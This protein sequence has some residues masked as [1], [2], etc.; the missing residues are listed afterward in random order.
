MLKEL[1]SGSEHT[2]NLNL[3]EAKTER[4]RRRRKELSSMQ[5]FVQA[6]ASVRG[7]ILGTEASSPKSTYDSP[8]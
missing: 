4:W 3:Y 1:F 5:Y 8:K 2:V 7:V 6:F